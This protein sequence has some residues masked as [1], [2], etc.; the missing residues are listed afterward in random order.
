MPITIRPTIK[1]D[2]PELLA[3]YNEEVLHGTATFDL[4][5]KTLAERETW[6]IEHQAG[7]YPLLT[8]EIDGHIAGYASLSPYRQKDAY[9]GTAELSV[10]VHTSYRQQGIATALMEAILQKARQGDRFHAIVSVIT[11]GN[12]ASVR[13]HEH[14]GFTFCGSLREVGYKLGAYRDVLNYELLL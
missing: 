5:P 1:E 7:G 3:I 14:F 10:Y 2:V 9:A 12:E 13:L 6:F 8:G 4:I 11:G